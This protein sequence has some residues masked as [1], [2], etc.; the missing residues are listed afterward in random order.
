M[1]SGLG[2][3][4]GYCHLVRR[5]AVDGF[6]TARRKDQAMANMNRYDVMH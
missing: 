6:R 4:N 1:N 5:F 2:S 3:P